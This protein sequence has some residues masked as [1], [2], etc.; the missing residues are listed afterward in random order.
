MRSVRI[1][2]PSIPAGLFANLVALLAFAGF[3]VCV[4]GLASAFG[5]PGAWWLSG[6]VGAVELGFMAWVASGSAD[7]ESQAWAKEP[8]R[9]L[10]TVKPAVAKSA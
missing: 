7:A 10:Q 8:T 6:I 4:G 9:K 2:V 3:A 5:M 1:P